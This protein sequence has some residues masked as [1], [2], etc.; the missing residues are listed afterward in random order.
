MSICTR[1]QCFLLAGVLLIALS[2]C[3]SG[4]LVGTSMSEDERQTA[5]GLLEIPEGEDF[6]FGMTRDESELWVVDVAAGEAELV[7][8]TGIT[9]GSPNWPNGIA[10]DE[11]T[12]RLY[13][14]ADDEAEGGNNALYFLDITDLDAGATHAGYLDDRGAGATF[15]DGAFW[16]IPHFG[17]DNLHRV[18]F[19]GDGTIAEEN[20]EIENFAGDEINSFAFGDLAV[21]PSD[22]VVFFHGERVIDGEPEQLELS[23]FTD[24]MYE[25]IATDYP[26]GDEN[27]DGVFAAKYQ[28]AFGSSDANEVL[29]AHQTFSND[30][31]QQPDGSFF[32]IDQDTGEIL[33]P[34]AD[35]TIDGLI[36][37]DLAPSPFG[38]GDVPEVDD[39]TTWDEIGDLDDAGGPV[40][41]M[42]L[43]S[44]L[45]PGSSSH[46]P[47]EDHANMVESLLDDVTND[48]EGILVLGGNPD[49]NAD[50]VAY[51]E[52]DVGDAPN[53]DQPVDFVFDETEM[54]EV[55]FDGYAMLGIVSSTDQ[56]SWGLT[57]EQNAILNDR[58][59]DIADFVNQ[60]GG[61]LGKTQEQ[62]D[63]PWGYADPFGTF[64]NREMGFSQ[65]SSVEV[66]QAGFDL[67]LTQDG[68]S[69]WCCYHETFPEFP[70]FFDTLLIRDQVGS[71]NGEAGAIGGAEVIIE[72]EVSLAIT[73]MANVGVTTTEDYDVEIE[74]R[75]AEPLTG[76][77]EIEADG[78]G[79][80]SDNLPS[81][82]TLN[83]DQLES[84][85][86]GI[87][88]T[89]DSA[90]DLDVDVGFVGDDGVQLVEVTME[91]TCVE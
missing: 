82:L 45:S 32:A 27:S 63:E 20:I 23:K 31:T 7:Y 30:R 81:N 79:T 50:I 61:L 64:E 55:D 2:G 42:G 24:G 44:E 87:S 15:Y 57:D 6:V 83:P 69:G 8:E 3:D 73:G 52:G 17:D 36:F 28:V 16:Y 78:P 75:G 47:P 86:D 29:Y 67:G 26:E 12:D 40:I 89:C 56:I 25:V 18:T 33:Q 88:V 70:D 84:W 80:V 10:F 54:E 60:G 37:T 38:P 66:L 58:A 71:G 91:L 59:G 68:M 85:E 49:N 74:N 43:D 39:E 65:Y 9:D 77:F 13:F 62:L 72:R 53:V 11:E 34:L 90:G 46:G 41:L 1:I 35:D 4:D 5:S 22:G 21:R 51:W 19:D 76:D 48:G 14:V